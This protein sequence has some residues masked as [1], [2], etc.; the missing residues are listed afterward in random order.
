MIDSYK[1]TKNIDVQINASYKAAVKSTARNNIGGLTR[2]CVR[3][4]LQIARWKIKILHGGNE[5]FFGG[6]K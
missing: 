1:S 3:R 6:I 5:K 2:Q 4:K